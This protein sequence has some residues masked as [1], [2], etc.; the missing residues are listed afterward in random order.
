MSKPNAVVEKKS[1]RDAYGATLVELGRIRPEIVA[2][3]A[4]LSGSTRTGK[5]AA[6]FPDRFFNMG[7]AEADMIST[8]AGLAVGGKIPFAS[9]FAVFASG[10]AWDQIRQSVCLGNVNVKI[11]ATHG[12][13]T[14]GEDGPSHQALEDI[15]IMRVMP[16]MTVVVPADA[17]QTE[18]VIRYAADH[19]GPM[20]IRLARD[21]FPV[22]FDTPET[23]QLGKGEILRHGPD[24]ALIGCGM[25]TSVCLDAADTLAA[26][27]IVATVVNMPSIKPIDEELLIELSTTCG[28]FVTAEEHS[29]LGG[30]GSAVAEV[31]CENEPAPV[32]R[33][34]MKSEFGKSG[35]ADELLDYFG[36]NAASVVEAARKAV[37]LK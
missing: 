15:A 36:F 35:T 2:L 20:Y 8:A 12:G 25:M 27:G 31:I 17:A 28:A 5:F 9:T 13:I 23:F 24:V 26:A 32:I 37:S 11:V 14:V 16:H 33:V 1:L 21:K 10:R 4:D 34:G 22:V 6:K 19:V 30:L 18:A 7:I 29:I 3:D